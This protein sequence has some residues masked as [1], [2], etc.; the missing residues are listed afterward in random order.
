MLETKIDLKKTALL[1]VDMQNDLVKVKEG[2]GGELSQM[3]ESNQV[4]E[5]IAKVVAAARKAGMPIAF[6]AHIGREDGADMVPTIT[7]VML[8]GTAQKWSGCVEGTPGA[9]FVDELRPMPGD[10]VVKKRK[11]NAF[12]ASDLELLL[13]NRGVDTV[14]IT[15]VVTNGCIQATVRGARERDFHVI[16]LSNCCAASS[17]ELHDYPMKNAFPNSG[18][19]RT[20]DE[21]VVA[22]TG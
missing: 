13:R 2:P 14:I 3:I 15:G 5:N 10:Y 18:R 7:D 16:V 20:S 4:V 8:E 22:I 19:V 11:G 6:I 1:V 21:M 12:Y 17:Q 9:D